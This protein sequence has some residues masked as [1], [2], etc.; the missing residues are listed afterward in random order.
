[1]EHDGTRHEH[2][3]TRRDVTINQSLTAL[4]GHTAPVYT[5]RY[6]HNNDVLA[7]GGA[8]SII[9]LWCAVAQ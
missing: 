8:E 6:D 9:K 2:D 7:S 5:V 4:R 3:G 1:M